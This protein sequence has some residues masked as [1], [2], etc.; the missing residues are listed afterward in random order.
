VLVSG[1]LLRAQLWCPSPQ[2]TRQKPTWQLCTLLWHRC[3][4][5]DA[6][7]HAIAK[8]DSKSML[9]YVV[10]GYQHDLLHVTK[11]CRHALIQHG[12]LGSTTLVVKLSL[13]AVP[14]HM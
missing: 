6:G 8:Q 11:V 5:A 3:V 13:L 14:F 9:L 12:V 4:L 2:G 1:S 10:L 7:W